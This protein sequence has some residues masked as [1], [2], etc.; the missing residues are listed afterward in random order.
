MTREEVKPLLDKLNLSSRMSEYDVRDRLTELG[1][2]CSEIRVCDGATKICLVFDKTD[3][4]V[5]WSYGCDDE[6]SESVRECRIYACAVEAGLGFF[7]PKTEIMGKW[8]DVTVIIQ[9]KIDYSAGD[10]GFEK[11]RHYQNISKTVTRRIFDKME[12]GFRIG[13]GY[14]R[15]LNETWGRLVISLYGKRITKQLCEFIREYKIND[16][17]D[18]NIGYKN[19][20]PIILDFSGY[21]R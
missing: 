5:K 21:Y 17:H 7:F 10:C 9:D 6:Q 19:D 12:K 8:R 1:Y 4:I 3:F 15:N 11:R 13:S 18:Y 16:L 14:D 2:S 20:K